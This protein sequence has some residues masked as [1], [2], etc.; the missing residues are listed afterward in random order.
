MSEPRYFLGLDGGGTKTHC[1]L[2]DRAE[3][4]LEFGVGGAT[5]HEVLPNGMEDLTGALSVI[6]IPLVERMGID[7]GDIDAAAFGIGGVDTPMQHGII[8][9]IISGLGFR[10]FVLANDACLGI[11]AECGGTGIC[12]INGSGCSVVGINE[13]GDVFQIGGH[14]DMSGDKGGGVYLVPAAIRC[15]YTEL[16]KDG[17]ETAMTSMFFDWIGSCD[18]A[19]FCQAVAILIQSDKVSAY[20]TVSRILYRAAAMGD[21][22]ARRILTESGEDYALTIRCVAKHLQMGSPIEVVLIGSHFT[23]GEDKTTIETIRRELDKDSAGRQ[24]NLR[25][26]STEPVAG[27]LLWALELGGIAL[28]ARDREEF[29][30]RIKTVRR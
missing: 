3:D 22:E 17:P 5:N 30:R 26:I 20:G 29:C 21:R 25:V 28:I 19:D 8:S 24:Y 10:N 9:Q 4:R 11:K 18:P 7:I 6:I 2:Y 16:F 12:A 13:K 27:A 14:N 1:V 15:V 23:K